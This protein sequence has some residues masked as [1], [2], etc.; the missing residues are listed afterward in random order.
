MEN[1]TMNLNTTGSFWL[2]NEGNYWS[3]STQLTETYNNYR[4]INNTFYSMT[5]RKHQAQVT[6]TSRDILLDIGHYGAIQPEDDLQANLKL[7]QDRLIQLEHA[8]NSKHKHT[9][10]NK[11]KDQITLIQKALTQAV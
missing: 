9:R 6:R 1:R 11:C 8:R 2:D 5:T 3:Y 10:I 7:E 4:I